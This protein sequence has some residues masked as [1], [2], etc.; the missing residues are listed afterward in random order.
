MASL[1]VSMTSCRCSRT[2]SCAGEAQE[3]DAAAT[4]A[5]GA[6]GGR[7][8]RGTADG[9]RRPGHEG[10]DF[11]TTTGHTDDETKVT[12]LQ[13]GYLPVLNFGLAIR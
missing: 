2:G 7:C 13:K 3:G 6:G 1:L 11:V 4:A 10:T 12:R 8:R 5:A 9:R